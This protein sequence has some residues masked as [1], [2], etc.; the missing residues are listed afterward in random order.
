MN[1]LD[2]SVI[3]AYIFKEKG[4]EVLKKLLAHSQNKVQSIFIH[5]VNFIEVLYQVHK[6]AP[7]FDL[8]DLIGEFSSPWWGKLNYLDADLMLVV[9][10][11]KSKFQHA[12]LADCIGLAATKIFD[13][14]FWTADKQLVDIGNAENITVKLIR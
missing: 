2:S 11:L 4:G 7:S 1:I 14:T 3:L 10:D 9:A 6:R 8:T 5:Q 13:G 12:S